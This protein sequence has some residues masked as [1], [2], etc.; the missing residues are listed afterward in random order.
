MP[1]NNEKGIAQKELFDHTFTVPHE[2]PTQLF[3]GIAYIAY[4]NI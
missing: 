4:K 3:T 2:N 1:K